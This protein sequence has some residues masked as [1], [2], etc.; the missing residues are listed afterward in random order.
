[1]LNHIKCYKPTHYDAIYM[2]LFIAITTILFSVTVPVICA[3]GVARILSGGALFPW[4][5]L[6][7]FF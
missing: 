1:M 3:I 2:A 4:I 6:T 5:K 7:T